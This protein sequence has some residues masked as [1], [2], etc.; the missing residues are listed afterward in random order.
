MGI[1]TTSEYKRGYERCWQRLYSQPSFY[2]SLCNK[3]IMKMKDIDSRDGRCTS[4]KC[5]NKKC[6]NCKVSKHGTIKNSQPV[7]RESENPASLGVRISQALRTPPVTSTVLNDPGS[8][9]IVD[10][11]HSRQDH[12]ECGKTWMDIVKRT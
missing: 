1:S 5:K 4:K 9:S 2:Q 3:A 8:L 6:G 10:K 7:F 12:C 11:R